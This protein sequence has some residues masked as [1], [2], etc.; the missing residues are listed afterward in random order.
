MVVCHLAGLT[1]AVDPGPGLLVVAQGESVRIKDA[2]AGRGQVNPQPPALQLRRQ[3]LG[4]FILPNM[5]LVAPA[6]RVNDSKGAVARSILR[7]YEAP[8]APPTQ[9]IDADNQSGLWAFLK[10]FV[11]FLFASPDPKQPGEPSAPANGRTLVAEEAEIHL[12]AIMSEAKLSCVDELYRSLFGLREAGGITIER[13]LIFKKG[14]TADKSELVW[15]W[16]DALT[17][18]LVGRPYDQGREVPPE[19]MMGIVYEGI[20]KDGPVDQKMRSNAESVVRAVIRLINALGLRIREQLN[21]EQN[22][23][24]YYTLPASW[25]KFLNRRIKSN[26]NMAKSLEKLLHGP[27]EGR[28][29]NL[30]EIIQLLGPDGRMRDLRTA[31]KLL[32]DLGLYSSEQPLLSY[33]YLMEI[34]TTDRLLDKTDADLKETD[35]QMYEELAKVNRFAELRSFAMAMFARLTSDEERRQFI[36]EYFQAGS[37]KDLEDLLGRAVGSVDDPNVP[38]ELKT[39]LIQVRQ[40]TIERALEKFRLGEEPEQYAVCC[41]PWNRNLLVDAGPGA[42]KTEVLMMR[43][44]HL[45]HQQGL[46]P[47]QVLIL[48]FNRA[49]V[50]EIRARIKRLFD[51]LGYGAYVRRLKVRTFHAFALEHLPVDVNQVRYGD[52]DLDTIVET[53]SRRCIDDADFTRSVIAG[54]RAILVDEF[55]DMNEVR[56]DLLKALAKTASNTATMVIGDDDQDILRWN[57]RENGVEAREYFARFCQDFAPLD[58]LNLK[59]NFRSAE[60]IVQ[61]SQR[62]LSGVLA[63]VSKRIKT[64]I[65]LS[66]R[67]EALPGSIDDHCATNP[68]ALRRLLKECHGNDRPTAVL[69][70]SNYQPAKFTKSCV[71]TFQV[72]KFRAGRISSLI[73]YGILAPGWM[74]AAKSSK[75]MAT[76]NWMVTFS[77]R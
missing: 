36:D 56:Y 51:Q 11:G 7:L 30:A 65:A 39:I 59:V 17:R 63:N 38:E 74:C 13:Y 67:G 71:S 22:L 2:V 9:S 33:S 34:H 1:G 64:D 75:Q 47:E 19:D 15:T 20:F 23:T 32:S 24:Y 27:G 52:G 4:R 26:V 62:F 43:A 60:V 21:E 29:V 53:F 8:G 57:R 46:R 12:S 18:N 49:V 3:D 42:G 44:A 45:I 76:S 54:I 37:P 31:L 35:L 50:H 10:K 16:V 66:A 70:R 58:V 55:Q 77:T 14:S 5:E 28:P 61:R 72:F 69:C 6:A 41:H 48:A 73:D 25:V 68:E 40:E